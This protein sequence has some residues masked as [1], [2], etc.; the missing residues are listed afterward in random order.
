MHGMS[1][2]GILTW[3]SERVTKRANHVALIVNN[4]RQ[5]QRRQA[6]TRIDS[7]KIA[8]IITWLVNT[9]TKQVTVFDTEG[10]MVDEK[11]FIAKEVQRRLNN[12]NTNAKSE[13]S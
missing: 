4:H 11:Q 12:P 1:D 13:I 7:T 9:G 10:I 2:E 8:E 5:R 3:M 6:L